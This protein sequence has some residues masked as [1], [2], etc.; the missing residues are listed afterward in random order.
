MKCNEDPVLLSLLSHLGAGFDCASKG[1]IK[2]ILGLGVSPSD[3]VF[4]NP[5]KQTSHI[6]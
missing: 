4:A 1:E 6:K 3:I 2:Q 5:C